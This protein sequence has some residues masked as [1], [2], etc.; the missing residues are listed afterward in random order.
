M[1]WLHWP[2]SSD[3]DRDRVTRENEINL[4]IALAKADRPI[5]WRR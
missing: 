5:A 1:Q 3:S 4:A 2:D